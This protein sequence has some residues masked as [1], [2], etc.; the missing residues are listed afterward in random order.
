MKKSLF[1][2][3][4]VVV[5]ALGA[6]VMPTFAH[7]SRDLGDIIIVFG[8]WSEPAIVDEPNGPELFVYARNADGSRGD[9]IEGGEFMVEARFG[10][11]TTT[12][13]LRPA[14]RDPGHYIAEIFPTMTGDYEF[15]V[16]GTINGIEVDEVFTSADGSFSSI[17]PA[18]DL[19]FP[20]ETTTLAELLERIAALE[21]RIAELEAQLAAA[22]S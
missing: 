6:L 2:I 11:Q 14:F 21:A 3:F 22:G 20:V 15:H 10:D 18:T 13:E 19:Q 5:L 1:A 4:V 9:R 7:E 12:R 17:E 8:W 16:T